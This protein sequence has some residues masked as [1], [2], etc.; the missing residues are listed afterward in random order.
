MLNIDLIC[1][2]FQR[3]PAEYDPERVAELAEKYPDTYWEFHAD[4]GHCMVDSINAA[5]PLEAL[6]NNISDQGTVK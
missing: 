5:E 2:N 1:I 4:S 3:K 6:P